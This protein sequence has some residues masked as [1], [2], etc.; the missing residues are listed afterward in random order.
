[1][2]VAMPLWGIRRGSSSVLAVCSVLLRPVSWFKN[3]ALPKMFLELYLKLIWVQ[4]SKFQFVD[5]L[6]LQC[7][8]G[9]L[10]SCSIS[11]RGSIWCCGIVECHWNSPVDQRASIWPWVIRQGK[12]SNLSLIT[13]R[14]WLEMQ[15]S[16]KIKNLWVH[17]FYLEVAIKLGDSSKSHQSC[18]Q[19]LMLTVFLA[20]SMR[21]SCFFAWI[22]GFFNWNW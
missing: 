5:I 2:W 20:T 10:A 4:P 18:Q 21:D 6:A 8:G 17:K 14:W 7:G 22:K 19:K 1:M 12:E 3:F 16:E 11:M 9:F 15:W 13:A